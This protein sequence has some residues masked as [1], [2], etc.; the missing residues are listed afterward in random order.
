M[1]KK[2][3]KFNDMAEPSAASAASSG[4]FTS[5]IQDKAKGL[6]NNACWVCFSIDPD[7]AHV[8]VKGDTAL[9]EWQRRGLVNYAPKSLA[10]S[11]PLC[12]NCHRQFDRTNDPGLLIIPVDIKY[13]IKFEQEDMTRRG[14]R[15][16]EEQ[17][18]GLFRS[19]W[20]KNYSL[21]TVVKPGHGDYTFLL[22]PKFWYGAPVALFRQAFQARSSPFY[23]DVLDR[24]TIDQLDFL[25]RLYMISKET[26]NSADTPTEQDDNEESV[27]KGAAEGEVENFPR[28]KS[29]FKYLDFESS[30]NDHFFNNE[31]I[32]KWAASVHPIAVGSL[33]YQ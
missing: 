29:R 25:N 23:W 28:K 12:L 15:S 7:V 11:V 30:S 20:L 10:N 24:Q 2:Q 33:V 26:G 31:M 17:K 32:E 18:P 1:P 21:P 22:E 19:V 16:R 14:D 6:C 9:K 13:S 8:F 27:E 3:V 5:S 4:T